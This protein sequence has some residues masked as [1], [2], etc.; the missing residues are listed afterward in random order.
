[1]PPPLFAISIRG[2]QAVDHFLERI[3]RL[4]GNEC[5]HFPRGWRQPGQVVIRPADQHPPGRRGAW[6]QAGL[7]QS[8][9]HKRIDAVRLPIGIIDTRRIKRLCLF[10]CPSRTRAIIDLVGRKLVRDRP[11]A[12]DFHLGIKR[13]PKLHPFRQQRDLCLRQFFVRGHLVVLILPC[14]HRQ[15]QALLRLG[16]ADDRAG[17]PSLEQSLPAGQPQP[18]LEFLPCPMAL[19]T[20]FLEDGINFVVEKLNLGRIRQL[21][22]LPRNGERCR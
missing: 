13:H 20:V 6:L 8:V 14:E 10:E 15:Q 9:K 7:G 11:L 2:Q 1:M 4:V 22:R 12:M 5:C 21:R 18:A 19:E 16:Q 17:L 3:R